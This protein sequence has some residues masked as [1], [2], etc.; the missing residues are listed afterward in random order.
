MEFCS[1]TQ[2]GVQ[3]RDLGPLQPPPFCFK[4]FSSQVAG[5]TGV[6]HHI[7]LI[8]VLLVEMGFHHIGQGSSDSP[9][10]ASQIVGFTGRY[11][12]ARLIF[13]FLVEMGFLH[14]GKTGLELLTSEL[15]HSKGN[16]PW[17]I[18]TAYKMGEKFCKL[19]TWQR[20][21]DQYPLATQINLQ[22]NKQPYITLL[23][24]LECSETV[25]CHVGQAGLKLLASSDPPTLASQNAEITG[26]SHCASNTFQKKTY[27][28]QTL[29]LGIHCAAGDRG[30]LG[31]LVT[32]LRCTVSAKAVHNAVTAGS[33]LL[34]TCQ[35]QRLQQHNR[36]LAC[37]DATSLWVFTAVV[38]AAPL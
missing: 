22:E 24:R 23:P 21:N 6:H 1:F 11:H 34:H 26:I 12:H 25:F 29:M 37:Q 18:K 9:A 2:A 31:P 8:F 5:I 4:R 33:V 30:A 27:M 3:R 28:Q 15:L 13:V 20:S 38:E 32:T 10:S 14:V 19:Y 35:Q 17:S 36:T 7:Q 16:Y